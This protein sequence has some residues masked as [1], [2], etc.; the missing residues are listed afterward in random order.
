MLVLLVFETCKELKIVIEFP[1][2]NL[3]L[4]FLNRVIDPK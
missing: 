3:F 2:N 4:F 1:P